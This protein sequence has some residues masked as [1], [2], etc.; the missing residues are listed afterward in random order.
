MLQGIINDLPVG[1]SADAAVVRDGEPIKLAV[2]IEEMP[3]TYGNDAPKFP[4]V[5]K[6]DES[7]I[8][9]NALGAEVMDVDEDTA[10]QMG[11]KDVT[12]GA[13]VVRVKRD[14]PAFEAGLFPGLV[15][16]KA[17]KK[18]VTS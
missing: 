18:A 11:L 15:I 16:T 5:P 8:M 10:K 9:L 1:K 12:G 17:D 14:T 13:V 3:A 2:K 7:A 6:A 4:R